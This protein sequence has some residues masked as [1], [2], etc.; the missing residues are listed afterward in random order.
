[1][2]SRNKWNKKKET[3]IDTKSLSEKLGCPVIDTTSTS[4]DGLKE[5]VETAI[6]VIGSEQKM[7]Y[8]QGDIDLTDKKAVVD[9]DRKRFAFV[10]KIVR[11]VEVRKILT[12]NK[13]AP[14]FRS[15]NVSGI[16]NFTGMGR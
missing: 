8:V 16:S 6:A 10:N 15:R 3:K 4:G 2:L 9:A 5:L 14:D 13:N 7:P 1:M 12:K 11:E